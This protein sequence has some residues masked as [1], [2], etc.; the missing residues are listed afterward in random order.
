M[1]LDRAMPPRGGKCARISKVATKGRQARDQ[2]HVSLG[3]VETEGTTIAMAM[4][5]ATA[6]ATATETETET[7]T[8]TATATMT[9]TTTTTTL[10]TTT[11]TLTTVTSS[12]TAVATARMD[13]SAVTTAAACNEGRSQ[14]I[15]RMRQS[16]ESSSEPA[17][18]NGTPVHRYP[19]R[20]RRRERHVAGRKPRPARN[21][22]KATAGTSCSSTS[23]S[24]PPALSSPS[25]YASSRRSSS[26][27][28]TTSSP[29]RS[30]TSSTSSV[31]SDPLAIKPAVRS[32]RR[33]TPDRSDDGIGK[34]R[35]NAAGTRRNDGGTTHG[36]T[37]TTTS[38]SISSSSSITVSSSSPFPFPVS[39]SSTSCRTATTPRG[40]GGDHG[41]AHV[42]SSSS[43]LERLRSA[44][45]NYDRSRIYL[46]HVCYLDW[47]DLPGKRRGDGCGGGGGGDDGSVGNRDATRSGERVWVVG[48]A[49]HEGH[50]R[51]R[52]L[53]AGRHWRPR[54]LRRVNM[55]SQP[56]VYA[57]GGR[58]FLTADLFL[59]WFHREFA[60][61]A[62]A[63]HPDGAVLVA[64]SADYLPPEGDCVAA[65]G[66]V[67]LFVVPKDCM[68]TRL[69][70]RE[71]RVRLATGI[72]SRARCGVYR[73]K[74]P[75]ILGLPEEEGDHRLDA[76][77][78]R[79]TL[80]E[81]FADLHRA[82]LSVRSETFARSWTLPRDRE[83][84]PLAG[85]N[86]A[87][88][89]PRIHAVD[90]EEDRMLLVELQSLAREV[91]L[92]ITD[93]ELGSWIL[94][95][96][97]ALGRFV[98]KRE[99]DEEHCRVKI[100]IETDKWLDRNDDEDED[101]KNDGVEEDDGE[102]EPTA[103]EA[104]GLL[105]RVL[106]WMEREPLD[107]GLLLA[108]RSMRDTAALMASKMGLAGTHPGGL[109][110]FC[111]NGEHLTQPPPA[112]MGIPPYGALDA[113]KAA[114][115]AGLTRA[116]MYPFSTGQYAYPML[117][118]EMTQVA[119]WH[120]PSMY[121]ISPANAGFRSPYPTSLPITSS[122]LPSDL[123]RF[124]PT[125]LMP[126]HPGL[127]PHA[128][129]LASHALVSS[130]PKADHSTLDHNHRST[131]EQK[132]STSLPTDNSKAQDTGQQNNQDKKKP[133]I[134]KPLNAFM[135][136]MKEMRAKVVA[137]CTLKESAAINQI[138]GRRWHALGREEQAKYYE[139]ARRERQLH[140]QLYPDW[141]SRANTNRTK[142]RK[143]KQ[144]TNSDPG[145]N[146][147]KKC[148]ARY[149]L[150]QQSQWC[151]PCRRKKKCIRYMGEGGDGDGE[152]DG[153]VEDDHSEDNLGSVGE[154]GTP[155]EDESL[156]SP[157]GLSALSSLASPSL[158]LPS[159]SSLASPC[160]CPL[161]PPVPPPPMSNTNQS[162]TVAATTTTTTVAAA[163][164]AAAA[165][166]AMA[167]SAA[168]QQQPQPPPQPHRNPVGT[169]PHDINNP[170]SV[171]QL[172]GQCIKS[173]P[174][175]S[176]PSN[177]AISVT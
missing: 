57:G 7:E 98:R 22:D 58:G 78:K 154:A 33:S 161:T 97:N 30:L 133:H 43:T 66:L 165:A 44:L 155:E 12:G 85:C 116:P 3:L 16:L 25:S 80:K 38:V 73:D 59:W 172:T 45:E 69:V 54:C 8:I 63:M 123:Y 23:L 117:S 124:S 90:Q 42:S 150:D 35:Q 119:S 89:P 18:E 164:A 60:V 53:V 72:L 102:A 127:S 152:A 151:K 83:D 6:T 131:V 47:R 94:D 101:G 105:S 28:S 142:K 110:F 125:G 108:V 50:H 160:P 157:G 87:M 122:S 120:T 137:E 162:A 46:A 111:P 15:G 144:D 139:L 19:E 52:L 84:H 2:Q 82:W 65:D 113:G 158:V 166:M 26:P 134:K 48:A 29:A 55:L 51:T 115:A 149:G 114:A 109:P 140:M 121:P 86:G 135:L 173:E 67:R 32:R 27:P 5:T 40:H 104:V 68:E 37:E 4:A 1:R 118:P 148:R 81:A 20:Q 107:P 74:F 112:H 159:P 9:T 92:E 95:E 14:W 36:A 10:T 70:V 163:A 49:D 75:S 96:E 171:N 176:G 174:A 136:Y 71:L 126:P 177:P 62:M 153:E 141:S 11:T 100:E 130:A 129:A 79:F 17:R 64:E 61:T 24:S 156:S 34:R 76:Y 138:L 103:G 106:T 128:H 21:T 39:T 77:L 93:D 56:V 175:P 99:P 88:L 13:K 31:T 145:G 41:V 146:N 169:N 168:Q 170:L 91:G 132:N 143:R 147:M 167:G